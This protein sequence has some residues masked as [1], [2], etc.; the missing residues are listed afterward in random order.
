MSICSNAWSFMQGASSGAIPRRTSLAYSSGVY[1]LVTEP[2]GLS[3]PQSS[4]QWTYLFLPEI[5]TT[6]SSMGTPVRTPI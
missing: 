4:R 1:R 2:P 5:L 3:H 6:A